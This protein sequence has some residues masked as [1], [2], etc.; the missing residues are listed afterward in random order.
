MSGLINNVEDLGRTHPEWKPWLTVVETVVRE[1]GNTRWDTFIPDPSGTQT[2]KVPLL[3]GT[4]IVIESDYV[5][6]WTQR[7]I[8]VAARSGAPKMTTIQRMTSLRLDE[9]A[10][11]RASLCYDTDEIVGLANALEVDTDALQAL[12]ALVATPFLHACSRRLSA[13]QGRAWTEGYCPICGGWPAFAEIRGIT[14]SRYS[15]CGRCAAEWE[16]H[17]LSCPYCGTTD[18]HQLISL[19]PE[20]SSSTQVIDACNR[21][22]GYIKTFTTLQPTPPAKIILEDLATV[23]FDVAALEQGYQRPHGTGYMINVQLVEQERS[24]AKL[25]SRRR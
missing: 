2:N 17:C 15:R 19:R 21:C 9:S 10:L 4:A 7:L 8:R 18:H 11:F 23:A 20:S 16:V 14:R 5:S 12:A 24:I 13:A 1:T 6:A 22:L 3:A 25:F